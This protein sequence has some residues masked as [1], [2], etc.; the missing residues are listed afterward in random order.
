M[1]SRR[2]QRLMQRKNAG[3]RKNARK[4]ALRVL[5]V[6][7]QRGMSQTALAAKMG[8]L[9]TTG[10]EGRTKANA[11]AAPRKD[12]RGHAGSVSQKTP[13]LSEPGIFWRAK[14]R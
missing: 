11:R 2:R 10:D 12:E 14:E 5:D 3:A 7:E 8:G 4:V 1:R 13:Y 6:L 9:A